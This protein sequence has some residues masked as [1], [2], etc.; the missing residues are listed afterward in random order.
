MSRERLYMANQNQNQEAA[1]LSFVNRKRED[2]LSSLSGHAISPKI[3][4]DDLADVISFFQHFSDAVDTSPAFSALRDAAQTVRKAVYGDRVFFRGLIE[5]TNYCK[6][7]CY[8]CGIGRHVEGVHR[9]RLSTEEILA[10]FRN[11]RKLG[12]HSF[13]LQGGE[14]PFFTDDRMCDMITSLRKEFPSEAIT[15]SIGERSHES[16]QRMFDAG[17]DRYLLRHESASEEHYAMLHP[18]DMLLSNRKACLYDLKRIGYQVGAGFMVGSPFQTA[19][20]LAEDLRFLIELS[21]QMVGMGPFIPSSGTRFSA[22]PTGSLTMTL[23]M[24]ALTRILLPTTLIPSTTALGTIDPVGREKGFSYGANVVMPN[25]SP[26]SVR[27]DYALYD[28]KICITD[29]AS[30]CQKCL[31]TRI[32][33]SGNLPDFSR[34]DHVCF[35]DDRNKDEATNK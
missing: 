35:S 17:A 7:D 28:N 6:N 9:Y 5:F 33:Q 2:A 20:N 18:R 1:V 4:E 8:Y 19:G 15:L 30:K 32:L 21:P 13:V 25:L 26:V 3:C 24:I 14:D 27:A 29:D 11:G 34:G 16:Y 31:T 12:Y 23:V 22:F 10:C